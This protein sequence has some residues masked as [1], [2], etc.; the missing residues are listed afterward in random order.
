MITTEG[1]SKTA[2][3]KRKSKRGK[4][5]QSWIR[6]AIFPSNNFQHRPLQKQKLYTTLNKVWLR[7]TILLHHHPYLISL[8]YK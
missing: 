3:A 1:K 7:F 5:I 8:S 6:S 2:S 4:W